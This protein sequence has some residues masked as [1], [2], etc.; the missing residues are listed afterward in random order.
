LHARHAAEQCEPA[1]H[2]GIGT[3]D[4]GQG[5]RHVLDA[6]QVLPGVVTVEHLLRDLDLAAARRLEAQELEREV[7]AQ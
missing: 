6:T 2:P 5:E 7:Q 4:G 3:D 1:V